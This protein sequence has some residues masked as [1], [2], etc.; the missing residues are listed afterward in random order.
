MIG[1]QD[2][3]RLAALLAVVA[4]P[5]RL[6]VL[7]YLTQGP[8]HVGQLAGLLRV[9]MVNMSHHLG[10]LR[11]AGLINDAKDGRRVVYSLRPDVYTPSG[12]NGE[13]G[14]LK[15]GPFTLTLRQAI[16]ANK[17]V[18]RARVSKAKQRPA[19]QRPTQ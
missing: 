10:V 18:V 11:Q 3:R 12:Q 9:P 2:A 1:Y 5:N 4:E 19:R 13:I 6:R 16:R 7:L 8:H 17:A 15:L 14:A